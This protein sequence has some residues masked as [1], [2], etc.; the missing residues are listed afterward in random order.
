ME[1]ISKEVYEYVRAQVLEE[2]KAKRRAAAKARDEAYKMFSETNKKYKPLLIAKYMKIYKTMD[3]AEGYV[4]RQLMN[5]ERCALSSVGEC[6]VVSAYKKGKKEEA[7]EI[8][9]KLLEEI[10]KA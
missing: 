6:R 2:E 3:G 1:A 7:N 4:V 9:V 10:L 8:A 5:V